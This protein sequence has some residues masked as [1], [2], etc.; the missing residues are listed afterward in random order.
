MNINLKDNQI[1]S[2]GHPL[3]NSKAST[4]QCGICQNSLQSQ[5]LVSTTVYR[6]SCLRLCQQP[7][8]PLPT[9]APVILPGW[10]Q[11]S[12]LGPTRAPAILPW[13][14]QCRTAQDATDCTCS[15]SNS[16]H[17]TRAASPPAPAVSPEWP[18][19]RMPQNSPVHAHSSSYRPTRA[20][21]AQSI[22][23][24]WAHTH[25]SSSHLT[26]TA[27]V[28]FSLRHFPHPTPA[29][30]GEPKL[31]AH[32]TYTG[33]VPTASQDKWLFYLICRSRLMKSN[34]PRDTEDYIPNKRK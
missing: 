1:V 33:D 12:M 5:A 34:K 25:S 23:E 2:E 17:P 19:E 29:S 16:R 26:R 31:Q 22:W 20:A 7:Q 21:P 18:R 30:A 32:A 8:G 24:P 9:P 11:Q 28:Q 15:H 3:T 4:Q 27:L 13:Q 6:A 10:P 14:P